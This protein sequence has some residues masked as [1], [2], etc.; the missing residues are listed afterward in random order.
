VDEHVVASSQRIPLELQHHAARSSAPSKTWSHGLQSHHSGV[1]ARS[2]VGSPGNIWRQRQ[3]RRSGTPI[4]GPSGSIGIREGTGC[5]SSWRSSRR[6][7]P[8]ATCRSRWRFGGTS[9]GMAPLSC[10][11]FA[12]GMRQRGPRG[13]PRSLHVALPVEPVEIPERLRSL[14]H[15]ESFRAPR[16]AGEVCRTGGLSPSYARLHHT[17]KLFLETWS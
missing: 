16:A 7:C 15:V 6:S 4:E 11:R 13:A 3:H 1:R 5:P 10:G 12:A 17:G 8:S 2:R 9:L 14:R